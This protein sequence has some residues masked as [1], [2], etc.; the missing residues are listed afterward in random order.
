MGNPRLAAPMETGGG[1][2][3]GRGDFDRRTRLKGDMRGGGKGQKDMESMF[4]TSIGTRL[5]YNTIGG[6]GKV[7]VEKR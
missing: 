6:G 2:G 3:V 1:T 5:N 7:H 4:V